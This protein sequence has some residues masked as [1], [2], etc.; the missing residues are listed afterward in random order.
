MRII[1]K[2]TDFYDYLQ[3]IYRDN[4]LTFDR[5]DS[6]VLTKDILCDH[7]YTAWRWKNKDTH[8][9]LLLQICNTFW[10]FLIEITAFDSCCKPISYNIKVLTTW[11]NYDK[12]RVLIQ[13]DVIEFGLCEYLL[14]T[15]YDCQWRYDEQKIMNNIPM[16]I[17]RIDTN[18]FRVRSSIN[19]HTV[20]HGD[21]VAVEKHIPLFK[22]C[23][24]ANCVDPLSVYLSL[25]EYFSLEKQSQERTS[26]TGL[27]NK[28]KI[29]NHGFS[30]KTSFRGK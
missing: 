22:A 28:E 5:T 25:D 29:E 17:N 9:F 4:S 1:D 18:D 23:G 13:L 27:T 30:T 10:L 3:N 21:K 16:L 26:S 19:K 6:F 8:R 24:I 20:Y 11:K 12:N 14:G 7:L 2:N 15:Y